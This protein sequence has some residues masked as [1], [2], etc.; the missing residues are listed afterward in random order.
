[1]ALRGIQFFFG[2]GEVYDGDVSRILPIPL[3]TKGTGPVK[4]HRTDLVA[5]HLG[6]LFLAAD[7]DVEPRKYIS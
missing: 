7:V 1:M 3:G 5:P 2:P 6:L 4:P